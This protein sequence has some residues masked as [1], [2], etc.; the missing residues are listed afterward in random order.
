MERNDNR[1]YYRIE[2][3]ISIK[4]RKISEEEFN[5][6]E[7]SI[8]YAPAN[9]FISQDE[10]PIIKELE[11]DEQKKKD[12]LFTYIKI[13]E[14]KLDTILE[15]LSENIDSSKQYITRYLKVNISGSGIRFITDVDINEGD[16]VE[17]IIILPIFPHSRISILCKVL[18]SIKYEQD[19]RTLN[20]I[21]LQYITINENNRDMLI[22]YIFMKEREM[23]RNKRESAG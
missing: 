1:E 12:P 22:K 19:N 9:S 15:Y 21:A 7:H 18:R 20:D 10:I 8:R 14:R 13:I 6:I 16:Y 4:F 5:L 11:A 3:R 2:D 17:L 23:L